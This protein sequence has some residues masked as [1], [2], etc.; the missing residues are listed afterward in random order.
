MDALAALRV[1]YADNLTCHICGLEIVDHRKTPHC[2]DKPKRLHWLT[3]DHI[4]PRSQGGTDAI[5]NLR[6]AHHACN[7]ARGARPL[8]AVKP[9]DSTDFFI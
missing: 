8:P 4:T 6:P 7:S 1:L 3:A 2:C 9:E 5:G